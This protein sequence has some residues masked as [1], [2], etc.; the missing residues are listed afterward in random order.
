MPY[1][2]ISLVTLRKVCM[3]GGLLLATLSAAAVTFV[4][5]FYADDLRCLR[6]LTRRGWLPAT[7]YEAIANESNVYAY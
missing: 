1:I 7:Y 6:Y 2:C 5:R 3:Q 4:R